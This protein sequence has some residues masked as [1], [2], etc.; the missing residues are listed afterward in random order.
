MEETV[1]PS[2]NLTIKNTTPN[3]VLPRRIADEEGGKIVKEFAE[4]N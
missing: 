1:V 2:G 4:N 3:E